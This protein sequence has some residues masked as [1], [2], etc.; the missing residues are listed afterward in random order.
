[1]QDVA[2]ELNMSVT[3]VYRILAPRG[4]LPCVRVGEGRGACRVLREDLESWLQRRRTAPAAAK[5]DRAAPANVRDLPGFD[6][7]T[8]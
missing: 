6:R 5:V 8:R 7:H 4:D 2:A 3:T 1:V